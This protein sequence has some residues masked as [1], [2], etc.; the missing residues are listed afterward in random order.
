MTPTDADLATHD[1]A[2][3]AWKRRRWIGLAV[4][5]GGVVLGYGLLVIWGMVL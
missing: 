5:A 4:I 3:R 1:A 2:D